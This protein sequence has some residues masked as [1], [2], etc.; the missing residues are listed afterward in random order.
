M[1]RMW[2]ICADSRL[3]TTLLFIQLKIDCHVCSR[4]AESEK[5]TSWKWNLFVASYWNKMFISDKT[6]L[7]DKTSCDIAFDFRCT[8]FLNGYDG[9]LFLHCSNLLL[10]KSISES[11]LQRTADNILISRKK[12]EKNYSSPSFTL[13]TL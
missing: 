7:C 11:Q 2:F 9:N 3:K 4:S 12:I 8:F 13:K 1:V 6:I 5:S 10:V